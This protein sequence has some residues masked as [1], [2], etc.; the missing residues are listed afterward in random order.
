MN[1]GI[2][3]VS[4]FDGMACAYIALKQAGI[5]VKKYFAY[6]IDK[7]AIKVAK[8]NFPDIIHLGD[9]RNASV[10]DLNGLNID[11]FCGGS[12]CQSFS[13][14]GKMN[15]MSTKNNIEVTSLTQ[16]L[17]LKEQNF[18]FQ[19]QSYLFWEY[20]RLLREVNPAYFLLENVQMIDKWRKI[21]SQT[22]GI[23][24]I[25]INSAL[26]SAQNR[27]RSY[28]TNINAQPYGLY[29]DFKCMIPQPKDLN[30][31]L[32]DILE[33]EVDEKYF[34]SDKMINTLSNR[35][36]SYKNLSPK[37][38]NKK[39]DTLCSTMHKMHSSDNY[40]KVDKQLKPKS[41]QEKASCFTAGGHS[42]GNHSDMDLIIHNMQPRTE[43]TNGV[44]IKKV[45]QLNNSLESGGKQP[46]QQN[47]VYS[48]DGIAPALLRDKSD[49]LITGGDFN[50]DGK[51]RERKSEKTGTLR[52]RSREDES[53][54]Q[55]AKINSRIRRLTPIECERLQTVPDN[56]TNYV[57]DSQRY[58]MIG[59]G[60][61]IS[62]ISWIFKFLTLNKSPQLH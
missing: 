34:L 49:L 26:V 32:K 51:F 40:I 62:V 6:E 43:D 54:S 18:E 24:P 1:D 52:A 4:C 37:D 46:Y 59:N 35:P 23:A 14:A 21:I 5:K 19:G 38:I 55:L 45:I 50:F 33:F 7:Y 56:Y 16:Y 47:R 10:N 13:F 27:V 8:A 2:V 36:T 20:V 60:W 42:G 31:K 53:C 61:T 22:L 28:W 15:G 29:Q 25:T 9:I 12:P 11:L 3:V 39:S 48:V 44:E 17:E 41:N 58:K 57:S 30:I